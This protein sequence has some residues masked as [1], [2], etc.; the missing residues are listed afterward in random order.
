MKK[1]A[2]LLLSLVLLIAG[3]GGK[4]TTSDSDNKDKEKQEEA[5][6]ELEDA[7][8]EPVVEIVDITISATGDVTLGNYVGQGYD[9]SFN[10]TYEQLQDYSYFFKNVYD[11]FSQDDFTLVNLEG[12]LTTSENM[13]PGRTFNIKGDPSY[14]N[15][16]VAGGVEGVSM[17]NNH[18]RDWGEQGTTDT[19]AALESVGIPYAYLENIGYYEVNGITIGWVSVNPA[20]FGTSVETYLENGIAKLK[21]ENVD[22][23]LAC[24]HWGIERENY[25]IEY[26]RTL[27]KKCIDWGAD[28]VIGNHPH[29]LQGIEEYNGKY[30]VYSLGNFC[31]GA[32]KNPTDKDT[33]I[34]QQTFQFEKTTM[35]DGTVTMKK[36]DSSKAQVIPCSISSVSNRND[37]CPTPLTGSEGQRVIDRINTY[38]ADLGVQIDENGVIQ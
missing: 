3:C 19:V 10:Q 2:Y 15:I 37:Y 5:T 26:Q 32:N 30:I 9:N 20:S 23:I 33:A 21:S 6:L 18:R 4:D 7:I 11:I 31:F 35:D 25:P 17:E 13:A 22:I 14:K 1:L 36:L 12:V 28:L 16:L 27:G 34:F 38:S 29:V 24:C 8:K